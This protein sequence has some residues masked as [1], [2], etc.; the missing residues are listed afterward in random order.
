MKT[1][2][3][4]EARDG[5]GL[6]TSM[7][8]GK[9]REYK[10]YAEIPALATRHNTFNNPEEDGLD[11]H[12]GDKEWFCAY[13]NIEQLQDWVLRSELRVFAENGCRVLMLDV[14]EYQVGDDQIIYTKE[15]IISSKD[16]TE[17]FL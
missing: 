12:K 14:L 9:F 2:V 4:V 10:P 3:R 11:I 17:L 13:K 6:F 7:K 16:V 5:N 15:S 1:I 8:D